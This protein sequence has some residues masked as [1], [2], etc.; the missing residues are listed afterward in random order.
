MGTTQMFIKRQRGEQIVVYSYNEKLLSNE[1]GKTVNTL[2][3]LGESQKCYAELKMP[4]AKGT[5]G[6]LLG[7]WTCLYPD[8]S[9]G[10]HKE[11]AIEY[12]RYTHL[13]CIIVKTH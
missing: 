6:T 8:F 12:T 3:S 11:Y 7:W 10:V 5:R 1:E 2:I 13:V 4:N 9:K